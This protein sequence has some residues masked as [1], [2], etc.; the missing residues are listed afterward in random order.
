MSADRNGARDHERGPDAQRGRAADAPW[1]I[2]WRGWKD[3]LWRLYDRV[4]DNRLLAVA[5]GVVF[6]CVLALFPALAAFV[7]LY[8]MI[9]DASTINAHLS[10]LSGILPDGALQILQESLTRLTAKSAAGLSAG[11]VIGLAFALWSANS[12]IKAIFDALN[13]AYE[14][15]EKRSFVRLNLIAFAF[16]I[17]AIVALIVAVEVVVAAPILIGRLGLGSVSDSL[18]GFLRWPALLILVV[19][20]LGALYRYGPSRRQARWQWISVGSATAAMAWLLGSAL[21]SWYIANFGNYNVTYGSLGA[22]I[23]MMMWMWLSM[24]VV[25]LGAELNAEIEHQTA[26]DSTVEGDKPQGRRGS[27]MADTVGRA[28]G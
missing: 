7:S 17:A 26:R 20:E 10:T 21:F 8:G 19:L 1:R 5:A 16:T 2:P 27:R 15:K 23:G 24:I 6:Y 9:A 22:A 13:V 18:I 14:E 3:I 25:L 12:G 28:T 4:N 11:V